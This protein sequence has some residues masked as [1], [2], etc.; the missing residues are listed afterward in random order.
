MKVIDVPISKI[1]IGLR[2]RREMGDVE[3]LASSIHEMEV[4]QPIGVDEYFTLVYGL[5]RL[6]AC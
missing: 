1:K 4:L 6:E 2:Y 3:A 5:W